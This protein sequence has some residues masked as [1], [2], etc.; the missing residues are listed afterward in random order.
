MTDHLLTT[1]EELTAHYPPVSK[2]ASIKKLPALDQHCRDFIARSPLV[3][4]GTI[5]DVS[6]KGDYPGFVQVIDDETILIPD[7][8]GNNL[9]DSMRNIIDNPA[10]GLLFVIPGIDETLRVNGQVTITTDPALLEFHRINGK[11]PRTGYLTRVVEA[12]YHCAKAFRRSK[13]WD[14]NSQI[15]KKQLVHPGRAIAQN[16][17]L[18]LYEAQIT[19][20]AGIEQALEE[21]GRS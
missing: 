5:G 20:D 17:G 9:I 19:Y 7:R 4:I 2:M 21:E 11:L 12:F 13:L 10:V 3:M 16:A 14:A 1:I 6:P 8:S 15:D 18:D